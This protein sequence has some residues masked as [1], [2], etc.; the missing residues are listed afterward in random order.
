MIASCHNCHRH[1]GVGVGGGVG[2]GRGLLKWGRRTNALN[3]K[4]FASFIARRMTKTSWPVAE[5]RS[6][7]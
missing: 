4:G 2:A 5:A 3:G 6:L 7:F 1:V